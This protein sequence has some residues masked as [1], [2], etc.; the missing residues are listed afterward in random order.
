MRNANKSTKMSYFVIL[1]EVENGTE[2]SI[3]DQITTKS[4]LILPID[5]HN[6]NTEFQQN[7]PIS[8][9]VILTDSQTDTDRQTDRQTDRHVH[10]NK[11]HYITFLTV[12]GGGKNKNQ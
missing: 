11:T 3:R 12:V 8:F 4:K 1:R 2:I 10:T 5:S 7:W 9:A 6:C